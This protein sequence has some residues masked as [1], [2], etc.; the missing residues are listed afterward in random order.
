MQNNAIL[1]PN[2][3]KEIFYCYDE[4]GCTPIHLHCRECGINIGATS[5]EKSN[6][7]LKKYH[8]KET[9]IEYYNN[10][11]QFLSEEGRI[12]INAE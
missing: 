5:F 10:K 6:E 9:Y 1:C 3:K 8:K 2:C 12:V 11:I 4:W 7:L